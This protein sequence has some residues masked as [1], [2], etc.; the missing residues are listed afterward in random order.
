M[1]L[2]GRGGGVGV[3]LRK[4]LAHL[5]QRFIPDPLSETNPTKTG[6]RKLRSCQFE[7]IS[8]QSTNLPLKSIPN[9]R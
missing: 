5:S 3:V 1:T 7:K 4:N 2:G 9:S 8:A 6:L